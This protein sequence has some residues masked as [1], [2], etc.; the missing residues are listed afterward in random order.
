MVPTLTRRLDDA[1]PHRRIDT[2]RLTSSSQEPPAVE[3][4]VARDLRAATVPIKGSRTSLSTP[5]S[6]LRSTQ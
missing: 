6:P 5:S 3:D 1:E 2:G 4:R